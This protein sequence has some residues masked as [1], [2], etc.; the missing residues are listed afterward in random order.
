MTQTPAS[1]HVTEPLEA[2]RDPCHFHSLSSIATVS[3]QRVA[4]VTGRTLDEQQD[5]TKRLVACY[6]ACKA[7]SDPETEIAVLRSFYADAEARGLVTADRYCCTAG[8]YVWH[9]DE[10]HTGSVFPLN[11][12]AVVGSMR[13]AGVWRD[14]HDPTSLDPTAFR[15]RP[16]NTCYRDRVAASI[17]AKMKADEVKA[18]ERKA[19]EH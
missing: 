13:L 6:N 18:A 1:A 2:R 14:Y 5:T 10:R 11:P 12:D 19:D 8:D 4:E 16:L 15:V 17:A 3:G 9:P 7:L